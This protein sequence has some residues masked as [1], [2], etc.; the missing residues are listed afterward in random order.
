MGLEKPPLHC[1]NPRRDGAGAITAEGVNCEMNL[2]QE[3]IAEVK[4]HGSWNS[5][6]DERTSWIAASVLRSTT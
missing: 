4:K 6:T 3:V 5:Q 2:G 1:V